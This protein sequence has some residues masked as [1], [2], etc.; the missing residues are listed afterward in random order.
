[1][2]SQA[3]PRAIALPRVALFWIGYL[4]ILVVVG[5]GRGFLPPR[6]GSLVWGVSCSLLLLALTRYF[7]LR[8]RRSWAEIGLR[9]A[10]SSALRFLSG[11]AFGFALYLSIL[12]VTS[13][14]IAPISVEAARTPPWT[15][16]L[17]ILATYL[18]LG[19][20]EELG[21]RAYTFWTLTG[22]LGPGITQVI[23]AAAF[24]A[25]H[26]LYGWA[27]AT[28]FLGV[29]PSAFL[30]GVA[31]WVTRGL[32]LPLGIHIAMNL[33]RWAAGETEYP[34][35]WS[36]QTADAGQAAVAAWAPWLGAA[37]TLATALAIGTFWRRGHQGRPT[38][39]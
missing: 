20:M 5:L 33:A 3:I 18:S 13:L 10:P 1:M 28:V 9:W 15:T 34:G 17:L 16:V 19:V 7:L 23:V 30:F 27:W 12:G 39:A 21:F 25:S 35:L 22:S 24:A 2:T 37:I 4:A 32:A 8:D 6:A 38:A 31:A 26:L 14:V 11:L 36:L 29:L